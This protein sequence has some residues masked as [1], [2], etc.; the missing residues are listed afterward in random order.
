MNPLYDKTGKLIG[1][2]YE[3]SSGVYHLKDNT[4]QYKGRYDQNNN[5]TRD[6]T[7]AIEGRGNQLPNLLNK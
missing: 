3:S 6:K 4:G 1:N 5:F 7:G 2:V